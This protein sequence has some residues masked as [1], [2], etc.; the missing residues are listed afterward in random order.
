MSLSH[1]NRLL[2]CQV[3]VSHKYYSCTWFWFPGSGQSDKSDTSANMHRIYNACLWQTSRS[4]NSSFVSWK[5]FALSYD[6]QLSMLK[7]LKTEEW[8]STTSFASISPCTGNEIWEGTM[9]GQ[10]EPL[11]RRRMKWRCDCKMSLQKICCEGRNWLGIGPSG[12]ADA[13]L[14]VTAL[15]HSQT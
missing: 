2:L 15:Q 8:A 11:R 7:F 3:Y 9:N 4:T 12:S 14:L 1:M 13:L 5:R 6:L 10:W